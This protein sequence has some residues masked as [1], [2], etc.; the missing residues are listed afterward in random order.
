MSDENK[1]TGVYGANPGGYI[2]YLYAC[3]IPSPPADLS[4]NVVMYMAGFPNDTVKPP[5]PYPQPNPAPS[6]TDQEIGALKHR[7]GLLE[8]E[9]R[10]LAEA[11]KRRRKR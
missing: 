2:A 5:T 1:T 11:F 6:T 8:E 10:K 3:P 4:P 7:V 9:M